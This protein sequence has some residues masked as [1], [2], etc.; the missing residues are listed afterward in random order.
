MPGRPFHTLIANV[1]T[2]EQM[3]TDSA[4]RLLLPPHV[5][6]LLSTFPT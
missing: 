6:I 3:A 1:E 4:E 2:P 5:P